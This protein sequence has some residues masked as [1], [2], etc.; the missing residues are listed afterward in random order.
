MKF[1]PVSLLVLMTY[2]CF[3]CGGRITPTALASVIAPT[4]TITSAAT[5]TPTDIPATPTESGPKVGDQIIKDG[6][7]YTDIKSPDGTK[8][9]LE[10]FGPLAVNDPLFDQT[11]TRYPVLNPDGKTFATNPD[12]TLQRQNAQNIGPINVLA[13]LGTLDGSNILSITHPSNTGDINTKSDYLGSLTTDLAEHYLGHDIQTVDDTNLLGTALQSGL[14]TYTFTDGTNTYT[15]PIFPESGA[16]IYI[17]NSKN[18]TKAN[19]FS[20]WV[21]GSDGHT[22]DTAFW[23]VDKHGIIGMIA[24]ETPIPQLSDAEILTFPLWLAPVGCDE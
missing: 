9:Y 11:R 14:V 1:H 21:D 24:S 17:I 8:E 19:G 22:F 10:Y 6:I 2:L 20:Q 5:E 12:G 18:A 3:S 16:T 13:E 7:T 4:Q 23:G 15:V